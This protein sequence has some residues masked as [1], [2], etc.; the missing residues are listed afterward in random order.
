ML[1]HG[2]QAIAKAA[3]ATSGP[4]RPARRTSDPQR[5]SQLSMRTNG[6]ARNSTPIATISAPPTCARTC[7][8]AFRV[9]PMTVALRPSRMKMAEKLA[10]NSRLGTSTRRTPT[11]LRSAG[12]T[13]ITVDR[14]PGTSGSTHG[15]RNDTSPAASASGMPTPVAVSEL[16]AR[17]S[18]RE[19]WPIAAF[20]PK[21]YDPR[22]G[23]R[24]ARSHAAVRAV[25]A[26][27]PGDQHGRR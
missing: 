22:A 17:L 13:P 7:L 14:Y 8:C 24:P 15:D 5:H 11:S 3:P 21:R 1:V 16:D 26:Y 2:V 20:T 10:M 27:A 12:V 18:A 25:R 19:A 4:P 6:V 23:L 9:E